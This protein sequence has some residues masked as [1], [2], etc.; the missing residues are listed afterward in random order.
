M[1][2]TDTRTDEE[3]ATASAAVSLLDERGARTPR[4]ILAAANDARALSI[5]AAR[6]GDKDVA[7][8]FQRV[9]A[10]IANV[11]PRRR[12]RAA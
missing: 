1:S 5:A 2:D 10:F 9:A 12:T 3:K 11:M 4:N 7:A 8:H 6:R